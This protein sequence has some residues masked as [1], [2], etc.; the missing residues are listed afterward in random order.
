[1][2]V[3]HLRLLWV[4]TLD[5]R[6]SRREP[7]RVESALDVAA[8]V[9]GVLLRFERTAGDEI[10]GLLTDERGVVE[11][12]IALARL[13]AFGGLEEPGWRIG[14]GLGEV[15]NVHVATTRAARG[16][17]Y[18]AARVAVEEASRAPAYLCLRTADF[19]QE[20][21]GELA[22]TALI[23][24][25]TL[26]TRRTAKGWEV[27]D[28]MSPEV[29]Q[30]QVAHE[31]GISESAISQRLTRASWREGVRGAELASRLLLVTRWGWAQAAN[32]IG[33]AP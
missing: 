26:L 29:T 2:Q 22:E 7:D 21:T 13:D 19:A 12:I 8:E 9:P 23:L 27:V 5:Q 1:M 28:A 31:L 16:S 18:I 32:S 33:P 24:L 25:R 3:K 6:R 10:Q 30:A 20:A 17:A 15:E 11:L 4:V 14:I